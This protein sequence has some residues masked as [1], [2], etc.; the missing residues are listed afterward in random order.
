MEQPFNFFSRIN[1]ASSS[2]ISTGSNRSQFDNII[3]VHFNDDRD[4]GV[5]IAIKEDKQGLATSK[6]NKKRFEALQVLIQLEALAHN[7]LV[8][9]RQWLT[10]RCPNTAR[11]GIKR[12]VGVYSRWMVSCYLINLSISYGWSLIGLIPWRRNCLLAWLLYSPRS[13]LPLLW[14]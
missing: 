7:A 5:E 4:G 3:F 1:L 11:L 9:A 13:R 6:P 10:A 14:A 8:W 12:L 2:F